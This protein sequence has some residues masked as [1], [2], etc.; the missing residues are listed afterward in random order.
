MYMKLISLGDLSIINNVRGSTA[1][2]TINLIAK[3]YNVTYYK[4]TNKTGKNLK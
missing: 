3:N 4:F 1:C 2:L